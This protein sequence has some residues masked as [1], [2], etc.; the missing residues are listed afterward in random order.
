MVRGDG[1]SDTLLFGTGIS[2]SDLSAALL[3]ADLIVG[4]TDPNN[5]AVPF[6]QLT[7][8]I[9]LRGWTDPLNRIETF[10]FADGSTLDVAGIASRLGT[11]GADTVTWTETVAVIHSGEGNDTVTSGGF[12]DTLDG[13]AG[14][15][16][17]KA[18]AGSDTLVG[19]IGSDILRGELGNDVY[20]FNR[21]DGPDLVFDDARV[22]QSYSYQQIAWQG[23][24]TPADYYGR[25]VPMYGITST[26]IA[27]D[28]GG[29][30]G[31]WVGYKMAAGTQVV[32]S[33]GGLDTLLFGAGIAA[34]DLTVILFGNDLI[35]GVADPNNPSVPFAQ[36]TDKITLQG[37]TDPLNRIETFKFADGSTLDVAGIAGRFGTNGADT[38]TW[39]ETAVTI[40]SGA[41]NDMV[42]TG[43]FNDTIDGEADNDFLT[44]GAGNDTLIGGTGA[45]TLKGDLGND[46]Y[47]FNRGDDAD[48]VYDDV[49]V[50]QSYSYEQIAWQGWT[51]PADYFGRVVP[52]YGITK[53]VVAVDGGG[54]VGAWVGYKM[55]VGTQVV[56]SD[57]G[58]DV[59][60]FGTGI[61]A[62]D[63]SAA[64]SG[65]D[66]IVWIA[67]PNNP[68]VPF[69]QLTDKI[70]LQGWTDPLNRIETF[71]FADHSTLD[72]AGIVSRLG[73]DGADTVRWTETVAVIH[74]GEGND[75]V[76]TGGFN[77]TLDG[78][79]GNDTL[80]G[81]A[82]ND[83]FVFRFGSGNDT[84]SDFSAGAGV[85]DVIE[86]HDHVLADF[87][88]VLA[89]ASSSGNDTVIVFDI[90]N[91]ITLHNVALSSLHQDDFRFV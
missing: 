50:S 80:T 77:D 47:V 3:G 87:N 51:T 6:A 63:L 8:K 48:V 74:S 5:P 53:T 43:V 71:K 35:V 15:D 14:D 41:G 46:V 36:L 55:I 69:A 27:V 38:I 52:S 82:G 21:G 9:T 33:D 25:I 64:L 34:S 91:S 59:L 29:G 78:G 68:S 24:T 84:I 54:G 11:N 26:V 10:K 45:D 17:L 62:S 12:N 72:V 66:L 75:T 44:S 31:A 7:D 49:R 89:A 42:I 79:A 1:G 90:S 4:V 19:G 81:G 70:T 57:G 22:L 88:A 65:T 58:A 13:G 30:V 28:G 32:R 85:G 76:T 61:S 40:H 86:I 23:W 67:D 37:W 73:T 20:V 16:T 18:G 60:S 39:N 83:T 2:A 56:R